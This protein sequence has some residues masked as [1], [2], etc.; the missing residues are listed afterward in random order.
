MIDPTVHTVHEC[1]DAVLAAL[2]GAAQQARSGLQAATP[3]EHMPG[4][5]VVDERVVAV[6]GKD[7]IDRV[8][9]N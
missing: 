2:A 7:R 6:I 8:D 9:G 3:A 5:I 1:V 4:A